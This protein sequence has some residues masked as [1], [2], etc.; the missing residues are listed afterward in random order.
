[1]SQDQVKADETLTISYIKHTLHTSLFS[2]NPTPFLICNSP[3]LDAVHIIQTVLITE[4]GL[5]SKSMFVNQC[6]GL[7]YV[8]R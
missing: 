7:E 3:F 2:I 1:M 4:N 6:L 5:I 8:L